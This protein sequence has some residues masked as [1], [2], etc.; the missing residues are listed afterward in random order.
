[1]H[2]KL[3]TSKSKEFCCLVVLSREKVANI[4]HGCSCEILGWC[5]FS[6]VQEVFICFV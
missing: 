6:N 2:K 1:M 4:Y 3:Q 5:P